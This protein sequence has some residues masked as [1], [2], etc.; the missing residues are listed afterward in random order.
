MG[1][2]T[3]P[4]HRLRIQPELQERFP[5]Y[6]ALVISA[7]GVANGPS[8]EHIRP[9]CG[10][11]SCT[12]ATCSRAAS[13]PSIRTWPP[14]ARP[15]GH[16]AQAEPYPKSAEALLTRVLRGE[17]LPAINRLVDL[18]NAVSVKNALPV[19]GEDIDQVAS[20]PTLA[21]ARGDEPFDTIRGGEAVVE[22]PARGEVVWKDEK[23]VTCRAWNWRQCVRTRLT[24]STR[25]AYFVL[26]RLEPYGID[27]LLAAGEELARLI[28]A[29]SPGCSLETELLG[30]LA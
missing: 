9:N 11:R 12:S 22:A 4:G 27:L 23:G 8:D 21:F 5:S 15:T 19:G 16:S 18:Y 17:G 28:Q 10:K 25:N 29:A 2:G 13:P 20:D 7:R 3:G 1:G 30:P 14:G 6:A 26:D 24:E